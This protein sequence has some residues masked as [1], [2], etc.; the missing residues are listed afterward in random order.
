[1]A[2]Q[3][4]TDD[5]YSKGEPIAYM[6]MRGLPYSA[7]P[8]DVIDW[9]GEGERF[10]CDFSMYFTGIAEHVT[11]VEFTTMRDGRPSGKCSVIA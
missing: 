5:I 4:P 11:A 9:L 10:F 6:R 7:S 8:K 1:M 3:K 2:D